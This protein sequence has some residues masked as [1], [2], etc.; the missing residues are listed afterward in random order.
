MYNSLLYFFVDAL[1]FSGHMFNIPNSACKCCHILFIYWRDLA[2]AS[3]HFPLWSF[4]L[5][6]SCT[7][8]LQVINPKIHCIYFCF[9]QLSSKKAKMEKMSFMFA[10]LFM[11]SKSLHSFLQIQISISYHI[12]PIWKT[13]LK[14]SYSTVLLAITALILVCLKKF[15][16]CLHFWK[17]FLLSIEFQWTFFWLSS[18]KILLHCFLACIFSDKKYAVVLVSVPLYLT[19]FFLSACF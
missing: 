1:R 5:F 10:H 2:T 7:L 6:L 3:F 11:I 8:F 15:L 14:S 4:V 19:S 13:P 16:F 9:K 12:P 18:L 17:I